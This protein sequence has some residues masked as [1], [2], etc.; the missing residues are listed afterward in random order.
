MTTHHST[1][2][3]EIDPDQF[4]FWMPEWQAGEREVDEE[5]QSGQY[6]ELDSMDDFL[7]TL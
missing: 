4:W 2:T 3:I 6:E 7:A 5:L 1:P